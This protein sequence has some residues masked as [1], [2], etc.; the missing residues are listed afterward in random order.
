MEREETTRQQKVGR[1]IQKDISDI[2]LKEARHLIQ[3]VMVTVSKVRVS[4]DLSFARVYVSVFPFA[5]SEATLVVLKKSSSMIRFE[6]GKRVK[7][8]LRIVPE[9][10]FVI[11]DS[12]EYVERIENLIKE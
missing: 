11:D 6:L 3:G 2:F 12:L 1:Q 10:A 7:N 4:P 8:Q 9:I 5:K